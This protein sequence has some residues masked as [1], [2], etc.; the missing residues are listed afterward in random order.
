MAK[1]KLRVTLDWTRKLAQESLAASLI[2]A[3][4]ANA[5]AKLDLTLAKALGSV[6]V[7]ANGSV[8]CMDC[9]LV[10]TRVVRDQNGGVPPCPECSAP[11]KAKPAVEAQA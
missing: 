4:L 2:E 3:E 6:G 9:G 8:V 1:N 5:R 10:R 7:G 11:K